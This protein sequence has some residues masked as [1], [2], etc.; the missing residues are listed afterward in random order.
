MNSRLAFIELIKILYQ[1]SCSKE[2]NEYQMACERM[3]TTLYQIEKYHL[4]PL[5]LLP[6]S[7][8]KALIVFK[9]NEDWFASKERIVGTLYL[10]LAR[11]MY[12][13]EVAN[14]YNSVEYKQGLEMCRIQFSYDRI[15][16]WLENVDFNEQKVLKDYFYFILN[17]DVRSFSSVDE[18]SAYQNMIKE[19]GFP[20]FDRLENPISP[21]LLHKIQSEYEEILR[22]YRNYI[23]ANYQKVENYFEAYNCNVRIYVATRYVDKPKGEI[24]LVYYYYKKL[25]GKYVHC[26]RQH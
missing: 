2:R 17:P 12:S 6:T 16:K 11:T 1:I 24:K 25:D 10:F 26:S 14:I 5:D 15:V 22:K 18:Y 13:S 9:E 4:M 21:P 3:S 8:E 7:F 19:N 20:K 23:H